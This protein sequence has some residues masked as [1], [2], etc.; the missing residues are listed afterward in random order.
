MILLAAIAIF[1]IDIAMV[2]IAVE[3]RDFFYK[4]GHYKE[5]EGGDQ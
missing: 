5:N 4:E 1:A 3:V 2:Y